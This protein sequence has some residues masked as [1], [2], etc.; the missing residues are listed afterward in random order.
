MSSLDE[1]FEDGYGSGGEMVP[2]YDSV[3]V[4]GYQ[5]FG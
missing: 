4:K 2:L 5:G 3:E 1:I